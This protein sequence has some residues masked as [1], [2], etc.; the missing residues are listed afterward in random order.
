M[1]AVCYINATA[2]TCYFDAV[3]SEDSLL[4]FFVKF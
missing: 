1:Y 2:V 4:S 3:M